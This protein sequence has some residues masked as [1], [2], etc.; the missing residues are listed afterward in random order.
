M[1]S[2]STRLQGKVAIVTGAASGLGKASADLFLANGAKVVYADVK[3]IKVKSAKALFINC[4]VSSSASVNNLVAATVKK[5]GRLDIMFN[6]AGIA[7]GGTA[8][9]TTDEIWT[10]TLMV[11]LSGAFYGTRAAAKYMQREK[12]NGSIINTA[13]IAGLVGFQDSLAYCSSKGGIIQLTRAAALDLAKFGIRVNAI[14]PGVIDTNMTKPYLTDKNYANFFKLSTPLGRIG[15]PL[16]IANAALYLAS[17]E[18]GFVT[19]SVLTVDGGWVA[20]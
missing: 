6:N 20:K 10:K 1:K 13:S 3:N 2:T 4:D 5:F 16:D 11:N 8:V 14:A 9:N 15:V 19:G 7:T 17:A 18:S 12:I